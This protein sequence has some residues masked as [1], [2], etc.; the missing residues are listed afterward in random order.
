[1]ITGHLGQD[2]S[3]RQAGQDQCANFTVA[4]T[5]RFK[6]GDETK[7]TTT[8]YSCALWRPNAVVNF[9]KKGQMVL[10]EGRPKARM[11]TNRAGEQVAQMEIDVVNVELLGKLTS[12]D[13]EQKPEDK[14]QMDG[15][16]KVY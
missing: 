11:Y 2:A 8:W 13:Q 9:L 6:Q 5:R 4:V 1:M 14:N 15:E 12:N 3:V 16:G 10:V 7:E